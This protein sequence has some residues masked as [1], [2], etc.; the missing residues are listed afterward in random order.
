MSAFLV[1][2]GYN[3]WILPALLVLPLIGAIGIW[4]AGALSRPS[5]RATVVADRV[6]DE[7]VASEVAA[8]PDGAMVVPEP[9]R[10][11]RGLAFGIFL[12]EFVLSLG[13]WW[14]FDP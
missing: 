4:A 3:D 12:L 6:P 13:L 14:S 5:A 7:G 9:S 8:T 2:F 1:S 11:A 10:A